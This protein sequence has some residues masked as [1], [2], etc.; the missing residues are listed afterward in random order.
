MA[1]ASNPLRVDSGLHAY[2]P[3]PLMQPTNAGD[4]GRRPRP[5]LLA[6]TKDHRLSR[7]VR[8]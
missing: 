3:N 6:A 7:V 8:S 2:L 4:S 1:T 5:G